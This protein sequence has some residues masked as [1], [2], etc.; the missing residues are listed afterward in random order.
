M[1]SWRR[2]DDRK[3]EREERETVRKPPPPATP[4]PAPSVSKEREK[5]GEKEKAWRTDKEREA[6]RRIKNETDDEG[7]TT[8]RR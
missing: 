8:V 1:S 4:T 6:L 5:E 7:W 3:E 2:S